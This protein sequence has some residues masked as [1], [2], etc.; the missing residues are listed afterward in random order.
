MSVSGVVL[1]S[2]ADFSDCNY[3]TDNRC[4]GLILNA[5]A[6]CKVEE[7]WC[8]SAMDYVGNAVDMAIAKCISLR[9]ASNLVRDIALTSNLNRDTMIDGVT[10]G[11]M[12]ELW[13]GEYNEMI[14]F[15]VKNIDI[16]KTDCFACGREI[17][18]GVGS[19]LS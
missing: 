15:I 18:G 6:R 7:I 5:T 10:L 9:A 12:D 8:Y 19:I 16:T 2:I 3:S 17:L 13:N 4:F 1:T 11:E 14:D